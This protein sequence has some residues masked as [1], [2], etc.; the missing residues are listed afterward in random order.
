MSNYYSD[1]PELEAELVKEWG[2]PDKIYNEAMKK[3]LTIDYKKATT[4][5]LWDIVKHLEPE[6]YFDGR[7]T[8]EFFIEFINWQRER[9]K[10]SGYF[11]EEL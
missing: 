8:R 1:N 3:C 9:N 2:I 4:Q 10:D 11:F 6:G 7:K 5:E